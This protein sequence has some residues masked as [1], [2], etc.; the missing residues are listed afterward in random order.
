MDSCRFFL[1]LMFSIDAAFLS[2]QRFDTRHP[3]SWGERF[4]QELSLNH[5][6]WAAQKLTIY[7]KASEILHYF[8]FFER[9]EEMVP[10]F[11]AKPEAL[12]QMVLMLLREGEKNPCPEDIEEK[13]TLGNHGNAAGK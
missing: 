3:A 8:A 2:G 4:F 13:N 12:L 5:T 1:D 11:Y 6:E 9:A 7:M 10:A